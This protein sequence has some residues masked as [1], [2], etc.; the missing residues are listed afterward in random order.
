M[1]RVP[2]YLTE[3]DIVISSTRAPHLVLTADQ[4]AQAMRARAVANTPARCCS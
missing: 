2:D 3:A 1:G 4:V